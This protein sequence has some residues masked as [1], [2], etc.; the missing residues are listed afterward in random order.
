MKKT[1]KH[2]ALILGTIT[3]VTAIPVMAQPVIPQ[4]DRLHLSLGYYDLKHENDGLDLRLEYRAHNIKFLSRLSPFMGLE[5]THKGSVWIGA[6]FLTDI[7][8]TPKWHL[9]PS[10]GIGYYNKGGSDVDLGHPIEF[11]SQ[12]EISHEFRNKSRI[13]I[14]FSHLSNAGLDDTNPGT[15]VISIN[16]SIPFDKIF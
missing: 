16:Y 6:G 3:T 4:K 13:G 1:H 15:E 8:L 11:R 7:K 5:L 12:I 10:I 9:T 14:G 2:I